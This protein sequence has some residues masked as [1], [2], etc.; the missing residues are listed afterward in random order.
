LN[1]A[2]KNVWKSGKNKCPHV[3]GKSSSYTPPNPPRTIKS[4]CRKMG[5]RTRTLKRRGKR[6]KHRVPEVRTEVPVKKVRW[7]TRG[8]AGDKRGGGKN[9]GGGAR[10]FEKQL[11]PSGKKRN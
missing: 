5:R 9:L 7:R 3:T 10:T 4:R 2:G 6:K 8:N 11:R 1:H